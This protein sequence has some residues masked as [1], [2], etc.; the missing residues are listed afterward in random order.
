MTKDLHCVTD[1]LIVIGTRSSWKAER[2]SWEQV[3]DRF[4]GNLFVFI[5][6]IYICFHNIY[7]Y[8]KTFQLTFSR[9]LKC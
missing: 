2:G 9:A 6:Y 7:I 8:I 4:S 3:A 1:L 5:I